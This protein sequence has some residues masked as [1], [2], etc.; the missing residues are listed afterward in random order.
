MK[1]ANKNNPQKMEK[2]FVRQLEDQEKGLN[3][4][5]VGEYLENR[6]NYLESRR[7]G[8]GKAQDIAR[9]ELK[10]KITASVRKNLRKKGY[11]ARNAKNL[12]ADKA[13]EIM[14]GLAA[15][16]D[17]DMVA[18]GHD[19]INRVANKNVNSSLGSQWR[20]RVKAMD[21][22]AEKALKEYG[23]DAKLN[24]KLERCK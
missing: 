13:N 12:S 22:A 20:D 14:E 10:E 24:I 9:D 16:H 6:K 19:K 4:L 11:S 1:K 23:P 5:T 17:P 7:K 8:T 2:E 3:K 18:G 15:L 21:E